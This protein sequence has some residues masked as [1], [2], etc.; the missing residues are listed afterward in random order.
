MTKTVNVYNPTNNFKFKNW[1][2]E[3]TSNKEKYVSSGY[4]IVFDNAVSLNFDNDYARNDTIFGVDNRSSS[5]SDIHK[6]NNEK[7][8]YYSNKC[9]KYYFIKLSK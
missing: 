1:L 6:N 4:G 3:A 2:F 7:G 5:H 8:K 9:E